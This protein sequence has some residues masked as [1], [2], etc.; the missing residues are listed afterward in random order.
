[1]RNHFT[2]CFPYTGIASRSSLCIPCNANKLNAICIAEC[3]VKILAVF[4]DGLF[5]SSGFLDYQLATT[6]LPYLLAV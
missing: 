3:A 2:G 6:F 1:M 5:A 4:F